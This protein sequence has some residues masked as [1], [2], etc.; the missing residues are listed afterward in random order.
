MISKN[1][2]EINAGNPNANIGKG[3]HIF[4]K[5]ARNGAKI[6]LTLEMVEQVP[7]AWLLKFVGYISD[8]IK[9]IIAKAMDDAPFPKFQE[10]LK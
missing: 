7:T 10:I 1:I 8:V 9:N 4:A 6:Q 2:P 3:C 5:A